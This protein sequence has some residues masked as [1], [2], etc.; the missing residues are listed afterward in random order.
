[1]KICG[2]ER[3]PLRAII[4]LRSSASVSMSIS[5]NAIP[6]RSNNARAREQYGHQPA[7]C[8]VSFAWGE[9][10]LSLPLFPGLTRDE[11]DYV[12]AAV[13]DHVVPIC[14]ATATVR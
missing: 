11:Q 3:R 5:R 10:T 9:G 13:H 4:S 7:E 2:T 6:L 14:E 8:P 1:M 12:I